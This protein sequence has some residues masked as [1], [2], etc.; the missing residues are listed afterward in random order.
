MI[1]LHCHL[2]PGV[3]D[4]ARDME[5]ALSIARAAYDNGIRYSIATPHI[6]PGR[7]DNTARSITR[8]WKQLK[9]ELARANIG[10]RLGMAAEVRL[11]PEIL[12]L[13][14]QDEIPFLGE[15][16][17]YR[18]MLLEFPH[19]HIPPGAQHLVRKL[20]DLKV[21]PIISHPE[22]NKDVIRKRAKLEPFIEMGCFLQLTASAVAG[23]FGEASYEC[24]RDLLQSEAFLVMATDAHNLRGRYPDLVEGVAAAAEIVGDRAARAL[25][26]DHP[27][28]IVQSQFSLPGEAPETAM[29]EMRAACGANAEPSLH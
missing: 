27:M 15:V 9:A 22:R 12:V 11:S 19:S 4:G 1:D 7:Y 10:L 14:E 25:V 5:Q 16:D 24:A 13:L 3:D 8:E 21:R 29:L 23:G 17:D 26:F 2:L 18:I 6:N 20:L 28:A